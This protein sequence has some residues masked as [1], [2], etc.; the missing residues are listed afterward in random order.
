ME[1]KNTLK[2]L[3]LEEVRENQ[4]ARGV[5]N[6]S[7]SPKLGFNY[8]ETLFLLS[9]LLLALKLTLP[10]EDLKLTGLLVLVLFGLAKNDGIFIV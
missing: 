5:F 7:N 9:G 3:K 4:L 1:R 2:N 8:Q 6:L 10:L